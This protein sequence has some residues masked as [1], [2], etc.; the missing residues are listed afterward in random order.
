[1][2]NRRE[3]LP[4]IHRELTAFHEA[5]HAVVGVV[6]GLEVRVVTIDPIV[7]VEGR[8]NFQPP[9]GDYMHDPR[10]LQA[11]ITCVLAG[12]GG[13][14]LAIKRRGGNFTAER[15]LHEAIKNNESDI[16]AARMIIE[17]INPDEDILEHLLQFLILTLQLV[18]FLELEIN[19]IALRLLEQKTLKGEEIFTI[20]DSDDWQQRRSQARRLIHLDSYNERMTSPCQNN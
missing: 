10:R 5:A 13:W 14:S 7:G 12:F 17:E 1:V 2:K 8:I 11:H 20:I 3:D 18:E 16:I 9:D 4:Q 19:K 15:I 6:L